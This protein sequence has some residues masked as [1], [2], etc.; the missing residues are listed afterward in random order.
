MDLAEAT[1]EMGL[2][3]AFLW[4]TALDLGPRVL[5]ALAILAIGYIVARLAGDWARRIVVGTSRIDSTLAPVA[6]AAL[7][8]AI[9]IFVVV[10]A[11]GQLGVQTTSVL[12]VLGAAGLANG[13]ALQGTLSNIAA[14]IMLLW[15]RPFKEGD[16]I[17]TGS[18]A[19]TVREIGLFAT[20]IDTYDGIYRFVPNASLWNT[21][22]FNYTRNPSRMTDIAIGIGYGS[23]IDKARQVMLELARSDSR[24]RSDP[25]PD[26]FV[27]SLGD[28]AVVLRY[29]VWIG[30]ANFWPVQRAL[31]EEAKRRLDAAGIE[32]PFPQRV[33]HLVG[34]GAPPQP[35]AA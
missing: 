19:G 22:V 34:D 9:L 33:M 35:V 15:L 12:A 7:R 31:I 11:L 13:L 30:T 32:I 14:G 10:A 27:D 1:Q 4:S 23:D 16:Y 20:R 3:A 18:A 6:S 25:A 29:R 5:A 17:E 28:S 26:V 21:P 2:F 8:Y 24:V